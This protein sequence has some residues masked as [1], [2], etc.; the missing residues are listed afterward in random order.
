MIYWHDG[1]GRIVLAASDETAQSARDDEPGI[2]RMVGPWV[3]DISLHYVQDRKVCPKPP[4]PSQHHRFDYP[5]KTWMLDTA[6]AWKAVRR[7]RDALLTAC[8][9]VVTRAQE[10]GTPMPEPWRAYRQALRD[11]TEQADPC[12][13]AWPEVPG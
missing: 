10:D 4:Q 5:T 13:I 9:W 3:D 1:D 7:K 12:A 6:A 8:D 11:I 2:T